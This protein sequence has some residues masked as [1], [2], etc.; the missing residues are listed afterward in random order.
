MLNYVARR[1]LLLVPTLLGIMLLNFIIVQAAPGGPVDQ[2][3]WQ[4]KHTGVGATARVGGSSAMEASGSSGG[5]AAGESKGARGVDPVLLKQLEV[6]FGLDKPLHERFF[7]MM[8][9][10]ILFDFGDS[11]YR[12][13]TVVELVKDKLPVS[14]S[15]GLW[16][17]LFIYLIS[18]P[19]GIKK[20]VKDGSRFDIWSSLAVV[21]GYAV[22]GFLFAVL[23]V[24]LFA[25]GSY[26]NIFPLRGIV[27]D[28]WEEL[29]YFGKALDYLWHMALPVTALVIGGFAGLTMLT[30]NSFMDEIHKQYIVTARAKG[31]T[32]RAILIKHAF[33][34]A[35][36]IVVAG[37]PQ[38]FISIFFTG[39][40]LIE[41][42]FS[43][44]GLGLLG[45]EAAL[46][47]DYPVMFGTLYFYT[48]L[49]LVMNIVSDVTLMFIDPRIDFEKREG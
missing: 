39:S 8:K 36:L 24:V 43:L 32:E 14:I 29:S 15:L 3:I 18:I 48:L 35:M 16:S 4:L 28:N 23:L 33:R 45:F 7:K 19:L 38:A 9:N 47:R 12:D 44:D 27:S 41:V 31:L 6:Q 11:F 22:P 34:N 13:R 2:L 25:G 17:T 30:K 42:I 1:L 10:Y 49:G 20:A 21:I 46:S 37:F 26:F 5:N 40:L